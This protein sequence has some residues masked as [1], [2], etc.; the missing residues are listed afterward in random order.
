VP[1][2]T[3]AKVH[4]DMSKVLL[5]S[6]VKTNLSNQGIEV[7]IASPEALAATIRE[8]YARWGKVIQEANIK[9]D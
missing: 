9:G 8:D 2:E 5:Q 7:S 6:D 3:I 1:K 4:S